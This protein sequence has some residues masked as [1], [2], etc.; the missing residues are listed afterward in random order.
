[1]R[2]VDRPLARAAMLALF[3]LMM[4][5]CQV[6]V[7][8]NI[9]VNE[10]GSGTFAL[11]IGF[12]EE[13]RELA[14]AQQGDITAS[15]TAVPPGWRSEEFASDGFEGTRLSVDFT[16][17]VDL[18]IKLKQLEQTDGEQ[19]P[20][21]LTDSIEIW[22]NGDTFFFE[23]LISQV[24]EEFSGFDLGEEAL[25]A[26]V[27]QVRMVVTLP[28]TIVDSNATTQD[29]NTLTWNIP[30]T[31]DD[32]SLFATSELGGGLPVPLPVLAAIAA[33]LGLAVGLTLY[34]RRPAPGPTRP[35][36]DAL[37]VP[38]APRGPVE[39]DPFS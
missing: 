32:Q 31:G 22:Q 20:N 21:S 35:A 37:V 33:V 38:D 3:G 14:Q 28:G 11:E 12:D 15:T 4:A 29:G 19:S 24:E 7:D 34:R 5:A 39:G 13:F 30:L 6:R 36:T 23:A 18:Q 17:P 27:F 1:M 26:Q 25:V 2:A 9:H 8:T 10:D 16:D